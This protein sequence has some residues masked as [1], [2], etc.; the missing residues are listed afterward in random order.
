LRPD[1][2]LA[3]PGEHEFIA[4]LQDG[5]SLADSLQ[6]APGLDFGPWLALAVQEQLLLG[7]VSL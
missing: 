3:Q 5:R 7:A 4:A 2:R 1:V 6:A